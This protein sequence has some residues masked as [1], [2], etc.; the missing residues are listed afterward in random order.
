[1]GPAAEGAAAAVVS[2]A[3]VAALSPP[4]Q[5]MANANA[6]ISGLLRRRRMG[7]PGLERI[8]RGFQ[9]LGIQTARVKRAPGLGAGEPDLGGTEEQGIDLV[10]IAPVSLKDLVK[11]C[12]V[13]AR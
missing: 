5:A 13:V 6:E 9:H 3:G 4:L 11:W 2:A 7:A 8:Q 12:A 1:M 10:E